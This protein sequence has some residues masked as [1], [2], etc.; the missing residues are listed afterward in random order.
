MAGRRRARADGAPRPRREKP[1]LDAKAAKLAAAD[2][3]S[4]RAWSQRDLTR[5]LVRRGAPREVA[6]SV[7]A[8]LAARGY[9]DDAAFARHFVE[10]RAARGY[11]A[12]R[13][14]ADLHARGV[15]PALVTAALGALDTDGQLER[16]RAIA[17]RRLAA[18]RRVAP[19]RAAGR[20]RD[21]LLRRGFAPGIT[22]R[23]V[24]EVLGRTSFNSAMLE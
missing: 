24:R 12:A 21:H 23:V 18:L 7:V 20:L 13:L 3:L 9:V 1:V 2:L 15:A 19:E 16:A 10:T 11:G 4:R 6:E 8:D 22:L 5:R 14:A 17:R